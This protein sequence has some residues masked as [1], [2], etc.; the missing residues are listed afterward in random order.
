MKTVRMLSDATIMHTFIVN[1]P[2]KDKS[3]CEITC[4][5]LCN[6]MS[7]P[8]CKFHLCRRIALFEMAQES[9]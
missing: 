1:T 6:G 3:N 4:Q 5:S 9:I 7:I 8:T 2:Q